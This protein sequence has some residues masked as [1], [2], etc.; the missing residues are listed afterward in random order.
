[1]WENVWRP[2]GDG[3]GTSGT[4]V[5]G[6]WSDLRA[7]PWDTLV[8]NS[9][10]SVQGPARH[11]SRSRLHSSFSCHL[12]IPLLEN[13]SIILSKAQLLVAEALGSRGGQ[14]NLNQGSDPGS[15]LLLTGSHF[16][17]TMTYGEVLGR[18]STSSQCYVN[19]MVGLVVSDQ[20]SNQDERRLFYF[21]YS[22]VENTLLSYTSPPF[23]FLTPSWLELVPLCASCQWPPPSLTGS[24]SWVVGSSLKGF[25]QFLLKSSENLKMANTNR[26]IGPMLRN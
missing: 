1:M 26:L 25:K 17:T 22:D 24:I 11:R 18:H 10:G 16:S 9:A 7:T 6:R 3:G 5:A 23:R 13:L 4:Q 12:S 19:A 20:P 8:G 21:N 15:V 14:L 2:G